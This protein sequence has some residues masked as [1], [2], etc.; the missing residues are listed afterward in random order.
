MAKF[1]IEVDTELGMCTVLNGEESVADIESLNI[2]RDVYKER[3]KV[4]YGESEGKMEWCVNI[5]SKTKNPDG[6]TKYT[7]LTAA[8]QKLVS[9]T[10]FSQIR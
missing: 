6:T 4:L 2:Y 10:I 7:M 8:E 1:S 5:T 9:A 3:D